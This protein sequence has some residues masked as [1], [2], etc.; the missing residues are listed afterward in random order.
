MEKV[1]FKKIFPDYKAK[2]HVLEIVEIPERQYLMVDGHGDPN[3]AQEYADALSAIYPIAYG[4]KFSSKGKGKDFVVPPLEC[5]WSAEDYSSFTDKRDKNKWNW[6]AMVLMPEWI[7]PQDF[8][9]AFEKAKSK[10]DVS[11]AL[12]QVRL[13]AMSEG[14]CV[15]TLHIGSYDDEAEILAKMHDEFIPQHHL[16]FNGLHHE[17]YFNDPRK[18]AVEKLR[19]ILRQPVLSV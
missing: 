15:Q 16:A 2:H 11:P 19:T 10:K 13:Q 14:T 4:I 3:T 8:E 9:Q 5:L 17:I 12:D 1:D 6:T 7:T 18:T